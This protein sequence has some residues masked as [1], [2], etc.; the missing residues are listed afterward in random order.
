MSRKTIKWISITIAAVLLFGIVASLA[1]E[2]VYAE[3]RQ[4]KI[5][6]QQ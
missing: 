1:I 4:Q 5:N 3:T 6:S 2:F